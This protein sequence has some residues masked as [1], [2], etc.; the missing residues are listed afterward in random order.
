MMNKINISFIRDDV[1]ETLYKN[2]EEVAEYLKK[3]KENS[4]KCHSQKSLRR[5]NN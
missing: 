5:H 4:E 1:L 2:S 3:E